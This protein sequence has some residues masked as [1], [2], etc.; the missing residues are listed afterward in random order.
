MSVAPVAVMYS[1]LTAVA[2]VS[3]LSVMPRHRHELGPQESFVFFSLTATWDSKS[4]SSTVVLSSLLNGLA[5]TLSFIL[6]SS[7]LQLAHMM[8]GIQPPLSIPTYAQVSNA[9]HSGLRVTAS[10]L[11]VYY[12]E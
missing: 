5:P 3:V 12:H 7:P 11:D 9:W 2:A 1:G 6:L 4:D 10:N 8:H